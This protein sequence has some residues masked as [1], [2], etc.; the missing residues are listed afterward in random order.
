MPKSENIKI[1]ANSEDRPDLKGIKTPLEKLNR[2]SFFSEDR[3]D[4]KGIKTTFTEVS[5]SVQTLKTALI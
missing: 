2:N 1:A 4:L 3:P 5:H